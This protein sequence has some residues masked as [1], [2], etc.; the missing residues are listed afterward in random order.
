MSEI[1]MIKAILTLPY[2]LHTFLSSYNFIVVGLSCIIAC[3]DHV[4]EARLQER[5]AR[6]VTR[7]FEDFSFSMPSPYGI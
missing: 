4:S 6:H 2:L 1:P 3:I 5:G 7:I